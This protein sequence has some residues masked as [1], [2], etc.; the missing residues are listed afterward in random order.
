MIKR[1]ALMTTLVCALANAPG[2]AGTDAP[3]IAGWQ[4]AVPGRCF[5][6]RSSRVTGVAHRKVSAPQAKPA[7]DTRPLD[8]RSLDNL[9]SFSK[10]YGLIFLFHPSDQAVNLDRWW[11]DWLYSKIGICEHAKDN[12]ELSKALQDTFGP[13]APTA[14]FVTEKTT[15]NDSPSPSPEESAVKWIVWRRHQGYGIEPSPYDPGTYLS[16]TQYTEQRSYHP[17]ADGPEPGKKLSFAITDGLTLEM[18]LALYADDQGTLP[19]IRLW[20]AQDVKQ[21]AAAPVNAYRSR[22]KRFFIVARFWSI[23]KYFYPLFDTN[24]DDWDAVLPDTLRKAATASTE[25]DFYQVLEVMLAHLH[26]GHA[27]V[28]RMEETEDD[29]A[30]RSFTVPF[31]CEW[32]EKKLVVTYVVPGKSG[33]IKRGDIVLTVNGKPASQVLEDQERYISASRPET[34]RRLAV[35][36]LLIGEK[37]GS[38]KLKLKSPQGKDFDTVQTRSIT[39]F[40]RSIPPGYEDFA[41]G[42]YEA[43]L[44]NV[45]EPRRPKIQLLKNGIWYLNVE[46]LTDDDFE[47]LLPKLKS[48]RGIIFDYRAYPSFFVGT[49]FCHLID[50]PI[51][52]SSLLIPVIRQ[53][54]IATSEFA[55]IP[56]VFPD[57][58]DPI[59]PLIHAKL[60]FITNSEAISRA[61]SQLSL[62]EANKVGEIVG[63]PTAGT[64][65]TLSYASAENYEIAWTGMRVLKQD[66]KPIQGVGILPTIPV[67]R[68]I[69]GVVHARD[70]LLERAIEV[71]DRK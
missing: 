35:E 60:V 61:E 55:C 63:E 68:T 21:P 50:H 53:P 9:V 34:L 16:T 26:D 64:D 22:A 15:L 40:T 1:I 51:K 17:P 65:G 28:G 33:P 29:Y 6:S 54:G 27:T 70:E 3:G 44:P 59:L 69:N 38:L 46:R 48:A 4:P 71:V 39:A 14:R 12:T 45:R 66:G 30:K 31:A 11:N 18:P 36:A 8:Q 13:I 37:G 19:H 7:L 41:E 56:G 47:N 42:A 67:S 25:K 20:P 24:K 23:L 5:S 32:I 57:D 49:A 10:T 43:L 62:V 58:L 52:G 2:I